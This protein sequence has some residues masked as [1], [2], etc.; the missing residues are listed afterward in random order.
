MVILGS[1]TLHFDALDQLLGKA[2]HG[3]Q[4]IKLVLHADRRSRIANRTQ[5]IQ[6]LHRLHVCIGADGGL[7]LVNHDNGLG[8]AHQINRLGLAEFL[9]VVAINQV[10]VILEGL[11]G[12]DHNL[13]IITRGK[14]ADFLNMFAVIDKSIIIHIAVKPAEMFTGYLDGLLHTFLDG[15]ARHN[16][17]EFGKAIR[18]IEF[19]QCAQVNVG[20]A[21]AG[22]H[23]NIEIQLVIRQRVGLGQAMPQLHRTNV[24]QQIFFVQHQP[25]ANALSQGQLLAFT[26]KT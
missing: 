23:L 17:D 15:Y 4:A 18:L 8:F 5:R 14:V 9:V 2:V 10:Q 21:G 16:D 12:H 1:K 3:V 22:F 19:Q 7:R 25:I 24:I 20:F 26:A 13:N 6:G 11:D